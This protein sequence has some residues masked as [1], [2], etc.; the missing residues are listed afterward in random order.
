MKLG[1]KRDTIELP[2]LFIDHYL[3]DCL[4]VYPLIYIFSLRRLTEG[5]SISHQDIGER[6][7]LTESEVIK[8]WKYWEQK[9]L[10]AIEMNEKI[11]KNLGTNGK[12]DFSLSRDMIITFL[13]IPKPI[14]TQT[15]MAHPISLQETETHNL[16]EPY[17]MDKFIPHS[18]TS[19]YMQILPTSE[20]APPMPTP[21]VS[22]ES[23]ISQVTKSPVQPILQ[24]VEIRPQYTATE[25]ANYRSNNRDIERLFRCAEQ[26]LGKLLTFNDMNV[27]FGFHDWLGLP[28]DVV[29]FLLTYCAEN[30]HRSLRYIEKCA[31]DWAKQEIDEIEKALSYVQSFDTN[32]RTVL[33]N[34][35]VTGYLT[36]SHKK[37][38]DKWLH[39]WNMPM[40]LII[41][42]CERSVSNT[43][44]PTFK[45]VDKILS[46]W[47]KKGITTIEGV[48]I[49]DEE[50]AKGRETVGNVT[51]IHQ[52]VITPKPNRFANFSQRDTDYSQFEQLERAYQAQ[53]L[54]EG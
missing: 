1:Y 25:L 28:L 27:V 20:P 37:F 8:A 44:K 31:L 46:E 3:T 47:H 9:G 11:D 54:R 30:N 17:E 13:P 5:E 15:A 14:S 36:D 2:I 4:P 29:E 19:T 16:H 43:N 45:Y 10:V 21:R 12:S 35:G 23:S 52:A 32:Y 42:A 24:Q 40:E 49:A 22:Q 7:Q 41:N 18:P 48:A 34:M 39:N 33:K 50:Y 38:I 26:A 51:K 6:F 53:K